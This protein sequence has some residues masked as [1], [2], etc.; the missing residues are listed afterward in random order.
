[1]SLCP[2]MIDLCISAPNIFE[3]ISTIV[4]RS[5]AS[6]IVPNDLKT[7]KVIPLGKVK[8]PIG[9]NQL[10]P[11]AIQPVLSKLI[12]RCV[13]FRLIKFINENQVLSDRQFG[14]RKKH[15]TVHAQLA[16]TDYFYSELDKDLICILISL[17]L[18]KA[19]DKV[20][21][22]LLFHKFGWY[23]IDLHWFK[24]YLKN[25]SQFV[26]VNGEVSDVKSTNIG[27]AQGSV[28]GPILFALLINDLPAH[29]HGAFSV[30]FA[31]DTQF[32]LAGSPKDIP[33]LLSR[34]KQC[35]FT[36]LNWME[37]NHL[38]LNLEK[39][40]MVV[41]GKPHVV[42]SVGKLEIQV[43]DMKISS[44]ESCECLGLIIDSELSWTNHV[45]RLTRNC[46]SVIW[47]LY[48]MQTL[49][50]QTNRKLLL[51]SYL[52]SKIRYMCPLWGVGSSKIRKKVDICVRNAGRFVLGLRKYDTVKH[53]ITIDL[54]WLFSN[55]MCDYETL[56][57][58]F[59]IYSGQGPPYFQDY[60]NLND[61][62]NNVMRTRNGTYLQ[63][64]SRQSSKSFQYRAK[65]LWLNLPDEHRNTDSRNSFKSSI[66][67]LLIQKQ[68]ADS[69]PIPDVDCCDFS[70]IESAIINAML[71]ECVEP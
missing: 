68:S 5:L 28:L 53:L 10:R 35:L 52:M 66:F 42:K 41:I 48:P 49:I 3:A 33:E 7:S 58:A 67:N 21:R 45:S 46:N 65:Q 6:G 71:Y 4:Q 32:S 27:V 25:R 18:S 24:S 38:Q 8:N 14:F 17:D 13:Y 44:S 23:N 16:L 60:L 51:D 9:P 47:S 11:I 50:S 61:N 40:K 36:V 69:L 12:E 20:L 59:D 29:L 34:V 31:D 55:Y 22:E 62:D 64:C 57:L 63:P 30:L 1:M 19:F 43:R 56:K 70:C 26:S 15:S 39:T 37:S 2:K 54:R